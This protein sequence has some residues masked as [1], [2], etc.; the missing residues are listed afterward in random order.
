MGAWVYRTFDDGNALKK[1][2][3]DNSELNELWAENGERY[4]KWRGNIA[5]Y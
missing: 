2:I 4:P 1:V 3:G 5:N